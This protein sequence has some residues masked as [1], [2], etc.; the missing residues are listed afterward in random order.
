MSIENERASI[1]I[2]DDHRMVAEAVSLTLKELGK[3]SVEIVHDFDSALRRLKNGDLDL[4]LLDLRMPGMNGIESVRSA[5]SFAGNT[6][7]AIFSGNVDAPFI[8]AALDLGL[9]GIIEKNQPLKSLDS[10]LTLILS[11]QVFLPH[12]TVERAVVQG[13]EEELTPLEVA[14][15]SRASEG[16]KNIEI[17]DELDF[18]EDRIKMHMRTI[19][20]K[21]GARNRAHAAMISRQLGLI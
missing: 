1:L 9:H 5:M 7:I 14:I 13:R 2:A 16:M 19:C 21:L 8:Q 18:K 4:M 11:G 17:A 3:Y 20:R 15:L 6:K 12:K 10:I